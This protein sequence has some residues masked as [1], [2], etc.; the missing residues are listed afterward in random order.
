[1]SV[2]SA[3]QKVMIRF[4]TASNTK[5]KALVKHD[6]RI[7]K[8][9]YIRSDMYHNKFDNLYFN[10]NS[11][12]VNEKI[13][14]SYDEYNSI[15][16]EKNKRNLRE[17]KNS[18]FLSGVIITS[19]IVNDWLENKTISKEELEKCFIDSMPKVENKVEEILG[20]KLELFYYVI[21]YD[22][23]TPHLHFSFNNHTK[24][25]KPAYFTLKNSGRL[26][27]FQDVVADIF[28]DIELER[29]EKKSKAKHLSVVNMHKEEIKSLRAEIK[30]IQTVKK[31]IKKDLDKS[32]EEKKSE[33]DKL[34]QD[35]R[36][37]RNVIK[38]LQG[39]IN[40]K[41]QMQFEN[42]QMLKDQIKE[43]AK[44]IVLSFEEEVELQRIT[45]EVLEDYA[46]TDFIWSKEY[47]FENLVEENKEL[48]EKVSNIEEKLQ[49][50]TIINQEQ[51][52]EVENQANDLFELVNKE[53][54]NLLTLVH[55][56]KK[57][58]QEKKGM[59][60]KKNEFDYTYYLNQSKKREQK[61]LSLIYQQN[62]FLRVLVKVLQQI[63]NY[64][65][66]SFIPQGSQSKNIK[67]MIIEGWIT[68]NEGYEAL[69]FKDRRIAE[70]NYREW[71]EQRDGKGL[72]IYPLESYVNY[73]QKEYK[74][75]EKLNTKIYKLEDDETNT[76]LGGW[77]IQSNG[78]DDL[79]EKDKF[80]AEDNYRVWKKHR[81]EEG[82]VIYPLESYV[83]YV[84][85]KHTKEKRKEQ[86]GDIDS[87]KN[88]IKK[89]RK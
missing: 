20:E 85:T 19:N 68:Q 84:P 15:Y 60:K 41:K 83:Q 38:D 23:K 48:K 79:S 65:K 10:F 69:S 44:K 39:G 43:D 14:N 18:D 6:F 8:P 76:S 63:A 4:E 78:Y 50:N 35:I 59:F 77:V 12:V 67:N 40:I 1:M 37:K 29:G 80:I 66:D 58:Y 28:S 11:Q 87:E 17:N 54:S 27:E 7:R 57:A 42:S 52:Q 5:S 74:D 51:I 30:N 72:K 49:S 53:K 13:N 2:S 36:S 70:E 45:E 47:A 25:G 21:H 31:D 24:D 34:D 86:F 71:K 88:K 62:D 26:S 75:K 82:L 3:P 64:Y 33:L 89:Q 16:K 9:D 22:E 81:K 61:L 32:K 46:N 55:Y 56:E 73:V